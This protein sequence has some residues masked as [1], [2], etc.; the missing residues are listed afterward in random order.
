MHKLTTE[1]LE[2]L[3]RAPLGRLANR[4]PIAFALTGSKQAE[5]CEA[6]GLSASHMS[7]LV[8]GLTSVSVEHAHKLADFFGCSIED[9]FPAKAEV[10]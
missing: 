8:N 2:S 3:Q 6:T 4:L 7:K 9:V 1:Q 5:A 10:V